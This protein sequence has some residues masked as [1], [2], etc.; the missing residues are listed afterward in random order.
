MLLVSRYGII[1]N[2]VEKLLAEMPHLVRAP[3]LNPVATR[4][5]KAR[6]RKKAP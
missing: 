6:V 4:R 5:R 1:V 2:L 3:L